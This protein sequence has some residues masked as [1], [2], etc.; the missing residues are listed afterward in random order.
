MASFKFPITGST[1]IA[2]F[3]F[4]TTGNTNMADELL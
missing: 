1:N 3:K 4:P 2:N